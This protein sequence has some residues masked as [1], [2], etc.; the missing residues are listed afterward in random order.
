MRPQAKAISLFDRAILGEA[1]KESLRK[2][3]PN[4]VM[5]NPVMFVVEV[6]SLLTTLIVLRDVFVPAARSAPIW[7]TASVS[8]WLWFTVVFANLAEAV[9]EGRGKAQADALRKA[10]R[11]VEVRLLSPA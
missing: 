4:K 6:G 2:L 3:A 5:R 7:F 8:L 9:A 10:R 1:A 11:D